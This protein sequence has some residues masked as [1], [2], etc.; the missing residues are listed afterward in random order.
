[1]TCGGSES[2][3][4]VSFP[5]G[6]MN[7]GDMASCTFQVQVSGDLG[8]TVLFVDDMESGE[9]NW[10]VS[11]GQGQ[12]N[13]TLKNSN[14]HSGSYAWFAQER[15]VITD[16]YLSMTNQLPLSGRPILHFWH[17]YNTESSFDG[18]VV[19]ISTDGG[20]T[21]TDLGAEMTQ[22][23]YNGS[24]SSSWGSPI[25]GRGAFTGNSGA[26][27]ETLVDLSSYNGQNVQIRFRFATDTS[28]SGNGWYVDD[29]QIV[30]E[31]AIFNE[32][33]V[34]ASRGDVDCAS[35]LTPVIIP[36]IV[37]SPDSLAS[38]QAA[39]TQTTQ[40]LNIENTGG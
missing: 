6:T 18:G 14:P 15:D 37:V 4:I 11:H 33:C 1:A 26:Y 40:V 7:S 30:D 2:G 27:I 19:E 12:N 17:H 21:W 16:Q 5:L 13:W 38:T 39:D 36:N 32:A 23:G 9:G 22:N 25:G 35:V 10:T 24:I 29:V 31:A 20:T 28:R 8:H 34:E 3:G